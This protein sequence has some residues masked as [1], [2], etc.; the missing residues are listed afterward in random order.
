[1]E[2]KP[3][4][5]KADIMWACTSEPNSESG[6]YQVDLCNLSENAIRALEDMGINVRNKQDDKG[7]FVTAKSANYPIPVIDAEGNTINPKVKI[8][9]GSK[10]V[11]L[12]KPYSYTYKGKRGVGAGINKLIVTDLI[13][14]NAPVEDVNLEEAL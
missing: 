9:N 4:K 5:V 3:I 8:G 10:G 14:Y 11:A 7:F 2:L 12:V 13:E 6:K 1:M